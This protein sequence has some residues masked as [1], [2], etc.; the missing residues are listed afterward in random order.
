VCLPQAGA[1]RRDLLLKL[2]TGPATD[3]GAALDASLAAYLSLLGGRGAE[4]HAADAPAPAGSAGAPQ[5][6]RR[7]A[8]SALRR[9]RRVRAGAPRVSGVGGV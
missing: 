3:A 6:P 1:A 9:S 2:E 5:R 8:A 4:R 7:H